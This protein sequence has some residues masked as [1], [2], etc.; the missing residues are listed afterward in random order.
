M[1]A[2]PVKEKLVEHS[3]FQSL[4][5]QTMSANSELKTIGRRAVGVFAKKG[6]TGFIRSDI[7]KAR[8]GKS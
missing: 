8:V 7:L 1:H 2:N 3:G 6:E 5:L 4:P